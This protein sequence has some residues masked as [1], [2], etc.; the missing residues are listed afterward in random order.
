MP[1]RDYGLLMV[2]IKEVT[3]GETDDLDSLFASD[4]DANRCWCMWFIAS[5]RQSRL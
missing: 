2:T 3:L 1:L 5:V 4:S